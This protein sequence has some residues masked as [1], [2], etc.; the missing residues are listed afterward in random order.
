MVSETGIDEI[1]MALWADGELRG[2]HKLVFDLF[3]NLGG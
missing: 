3:T 2:G 1:K